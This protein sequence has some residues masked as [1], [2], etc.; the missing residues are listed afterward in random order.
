M[1]MKRYAESK[2]TLQR[3]LQMA[4]DGDLA[5]SAREMLASLPK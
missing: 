4:P 5:K 2:A 1:K 3:Y